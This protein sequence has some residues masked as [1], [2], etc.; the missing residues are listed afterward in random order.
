MVSS[1][2][3]LTDNLNKDQQY[4]DTNDIEHNTKIKYKLKTNCNTN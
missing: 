2:T 1:E 4:E 3:K